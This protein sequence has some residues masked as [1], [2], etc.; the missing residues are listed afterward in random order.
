MMQ[1]ENPQ[2][3]PPSRYRTIRR[4][5]GN[6]SSSSQPPALAP[7]QQS[8]P[9]LA[10]AP[11]IDSI[12]SP[13]PVV[14]QPLARNPSKFRKILRLNTKDVPPTP[15]PPIPSTAAAP[16]GGKL[17]KSSHSPQKTTSRFGRRRGKSTGAMGESSAEEEAGGAARC[18]GDM[19]RIDF[20]FLSVYSA[21]NLQVFSCL[22]AGRLTLMQVLS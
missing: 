9:K 10:A 14:E 19:V 13:K 11:L 7:Q 8:R 21:M 2:H 16:H 3:A 20:S 15:V 22:L 1:A 5:L 6:R 18:E 4:K 17:T 12:G